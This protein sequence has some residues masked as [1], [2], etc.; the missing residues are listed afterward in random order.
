M[1][2]IRDI[3]EVKKEGAVDKKVQNRHDIGD[4]LWGEPLFSEQQGSA[5]YRICFGYIV[6]YS[7]I[8]PNLTEKWRNVHWR[9]NGSAIL[10]SDT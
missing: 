8:C 1:L 9:F 10:L 5:Q 2:S 7:E 3:E 6:C 4:V